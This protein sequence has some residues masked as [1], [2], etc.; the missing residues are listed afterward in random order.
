MQVEQST[1]LS[2]IEKENIK[3][4]STGILLLAAIGLSSFIN[5]LFFHTVAELFSVVIA[6]TIFIIAFNTRMIS[7]NN[8]LLFLGINYLFVG[9]IDL[10]HTLSYKGM[11]I[12][13][14]Y[15]ANLPTQLWISAR[16]MESISL[17]IAPIFFKHKLRFNFAFILYVCLTTLLLTFMFVWPI[18]PDCFIEGTG[19][20]PFK[21]VSEYI[22]SLIL[23]T[24]VFH[25]YLKRTHLDKTVFNLIIL[26]LFLTIISEVFFT[27]YVN[28]YGISNLVGHIFKIISFFLIYHAVIVVTLTNPY[29]G[30]FRELAES[31]SS[32]NQIITE[33]KEAMNHVKLL[34]GFLPI[35][36]SCKQIR[37]DK[38]YWSQVE[39][40]ISQ[41]SEAKFT[42]G[43]CP[44]CAQKLYPDLYP[45]DHKGEK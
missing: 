36:S 15:G 28:V 10:M 41:H 33:L 44:E 32:K 30:L 21:K 13:S 8:Y 19:L 17:A 12:F 27:F 37:D 45:K 35:C 11:N 1:I 40:Y 24:A 14:G 22:I 25:L 4:Y 5:F 31:E 43:I 7:D 9:F 26:S 6:C 23:A 20:T 34:R 16:Y 29:K 39:E 18:F 2:N 3:F 42:H 38:G